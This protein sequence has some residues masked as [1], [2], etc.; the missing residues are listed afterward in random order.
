MASG[1]GSHCY[2]EWPNCA[3]RFV[4]C[5]VDIVE[6]VVSPSVAW[7]VGSWLLSV[8]TRPAFLAWPSVMP[9][10]PL[11]IIRRLTASKHS[12][13][14][15]QDVLPTVS[16]AMLVCYCLPLQPHVMLWCLWWWA[17]N[18]HCLKWQLFLQQSLG[19]VHCDGGTLYCNDTL[20]M[21]DQPGG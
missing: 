14:C 11:S 21:C 6:P 1:K 10:S 16:W 15:C 12:C 18:Q 8:V 2:S 9:P 4:C 13:C 19:T 3:A 20:S 17:C 5:S 7:S